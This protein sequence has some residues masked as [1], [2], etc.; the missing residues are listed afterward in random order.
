MK[1]GWLEFGRFIL[2]LVMFFV[3]IDLLKTNNELK[4]EL[5]LNFRNLIN[6]TDDLINDTKKVDLEEVI[7]T[8]Q[9]SQIVRR[10]S[11]QFWNL[12]TEY[13][14]LTKNDVGKLGR[15]LGEVAQ[16]EGLLADNGRWTPSQ[17]EQHEKALVTLELILRDFSSING[18][19]KYWYQLIEYIDKRIESEGL[20]L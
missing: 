8:E 15:I 1:K 4:K 19:D 11:S 14:G 6:E 20:E 12:Q 3:I 10:Y 7:K 13:Y 2:L 5:G 17:K 16:L 18:S 9:G